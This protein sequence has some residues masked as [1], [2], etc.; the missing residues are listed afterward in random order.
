MRGKAGQRIENGFWQLFLRLMFLQQARRRLTAREMN[1][2]HCSNAYQGSYD[3]FM[4]IFWLTDHPS[5]LNLAET[6]V[7]LFVVTLYNRF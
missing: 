4:N 3:R 5:P 6:L 2:N 7:N 1:L